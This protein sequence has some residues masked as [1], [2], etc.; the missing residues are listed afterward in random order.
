MS[1]EVYWGIPGIATASIVLAVLAVVVR[2]VTPGPARTALLVLVAAAFTYCLG[3]GLARLAAAAGAVEDATAWFTVR[4]FGI[5]VA[6][7]AFIHMAGATTPLHERPWFRP[8]L[9]LFYTG[10]L[11]C[12]L[13][14]VGTKLIIADVQVQNQ[15]LVVT[16]GPA[17]GAFGVYGL[18]VSLA[19]GVVFLRYARTAP[20]AADRSAARLSA[21]ATIL[22]FTAGAVFLLLVY[23]GL[24]PTLDPIVPF[25]AASVMIFAGIMFTR[26]VPAATLAAMRTIFA[27][28]P[29]GLVI[30]DR[31]GLVT[32]ANP[33]ASAI[34]AVS[35]AGLEGEPLQSALGRAAL[36]EE[37]RLRLQDA[38]KRVD[39][40][41]ERL[42]TMDVEVPGPPSRAFHVT[43]AMAEVGGLRRGGTAPDA[44]RDRFT[45]LALHEETDARSREI[46][47]SR[48][49]EVKDLFIAMIGHDLKAP[50]S[51]I[52]GYGELIALDAQ[53]APDSLAVYRYAQSILGSARQIQMM[54]ENARLFSRLV[55]PQ[56]ILRSRE[57]VDLPA[58]VQKEVANLHQ[59]AERRGVKVGVDIGGGADHLRVVAAPIIRSVFQN[60]IDNAVKYTAEKT[61][62][63]VRIARDGQTA[64]VEITDE[65]P[66][67]PPDKREAIFRRF[68]RLEQT[69][70][71]TEGLGLGLA[72]TRQL[73]ELHGGTITITGRRDGKS[74]ACFEVRLPLETA[75]A[76]PAEGGKKE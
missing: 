36:P 75:G 26:E 44:G 41:D 27:S 38:A 3:D 47:L 61:A 13:V 19:A 25:L 53:G 48:A 18:A 62:V 7:A 73:V 65:G 14:R 34:L 16:A 22:P 1:G 56:D 6:P 49:N 58:L 32:F 20:T 11:V 64:L 9:P 15:L 43:V 66:G 71:K 45:F 74:G 5:M 10:A 59:A 42:V 46:L 70:T 12:I 4:F 40:G 17:Y 33:A 54:M 60:L 35:G 37:A 39:R 24:S 30:A 72:I 29:D 51:A 2:Y 8:A 21:A 55:D 57:S 69:R 76:D 68:T 63:G 23:R 31:R 28:L 52:S 67:V 50:L